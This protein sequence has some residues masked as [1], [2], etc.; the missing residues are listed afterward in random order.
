MNLGSGELALKYMNG[1]SCENK[2]RCRPG[3]SSLTVPSWGLCR[4]RNKNCC[5]PACSSRVRGQGS[6]LSTKPP[7]GGA[8]LLKLTAAPPN[9]L[10]G[11][12]IELQACRQT[13][14]LSFSYSPGIRWV[15]FKTSNLTNLCLCCCSFHTFL[16]LQ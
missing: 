6:F 3:T 13:A 14:A 10:A 5:N 16:S 4:C 11:S 2:T 7:Q 12:E 1:M 15:F 9:S 8:Q